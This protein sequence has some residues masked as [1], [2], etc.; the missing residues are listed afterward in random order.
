MAASALM[1]MFAA[2]LLTGCCN[3]T[4]WRLHGRVEWHVR[5]TYDIE[6]GQHSVSE[7]RE[8]TTTEQ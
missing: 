6:R 5:A 3:A 7:R 1:K 8:T 2:F 4:P